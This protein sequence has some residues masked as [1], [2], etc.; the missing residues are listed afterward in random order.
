MSFA[1]LAKLHAS[2]IV[3]GAVGEEVEYFAYPSGAWRSLW[4]VVTRDPVDEFG[5]ALSNHI[6]VLISKAD[7]PAVNIQKDR[8]RLAVVNV[9]DE[10]KE[11]AVVRALSSYLGYYWLECM[12]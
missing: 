7:L 4:A 3:L 6:R 2:G 8:V 9:G 1:D 12:Q 11:Y 5:A 10:R